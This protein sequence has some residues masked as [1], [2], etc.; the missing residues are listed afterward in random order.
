MKAPYTVVHL[1]TGVKLIAPV[2]HTFTD[3]QI[4]QWK[5]NISRVLAAPDGYITVDHENGHIL[6]PVRMITHVEV[7]LREVEDVPFMG[8]HEHTWRTEQE[9]PDGTWIVQVCEECGAEQP[10]LV[11]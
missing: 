1:V 4:E 11:D 6:A 10:R 9:G 8:K 2:V 5:D 7:V 3:L